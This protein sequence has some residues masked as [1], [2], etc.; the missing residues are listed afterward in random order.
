MQPH[1]TKPPQTP[2]PL[3]IHQLALSAMVGALGDALAEIHNPGACR[4]RGFDITER[5][6]AVLASARAVL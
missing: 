6:D 3:V 4:D 2:S 5:I 1:F